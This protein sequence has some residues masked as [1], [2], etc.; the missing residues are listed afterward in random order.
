MGFTRE[1]D[2]YFG[3]GIGGNLQNRPDMAR[4]NTN[5]YPNKILVYK[6]PLPPVSDYPHA[7]ESR[8]A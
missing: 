8:F 5:L 7:A 3:G 1:P 2:E 4:L 6:G